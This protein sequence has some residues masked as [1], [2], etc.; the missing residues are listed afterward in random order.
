ME[1]ILGAPHVRKDG[2]SGR[3]DAERTPERDAERV[4]R[5]PAEGRRRE[6]QQRCDAEMKFTEF[7]E[8]FGLKRLL[9][10]L[11]TFEHTSSKSFLSS[12]SI[13]SSLLSSVSTA[14]DRAIRLS[15]RLMTSSA[16]KIEA[17]RMPMASMAIQPTAF[18]PIMRAT[19]CLKEV[20]Q[21]ATL[22]THL[23]YII[24]SVALFTASSRMFSVTKQAE[25]PTT[26]SKSATQAKLNH[27]VRPANAY[28]QLTGSTELRFV[29]P[30]PHAQPNYTVECDSH[31]TQKK[32]LWNGE[33]SGCLPCHFPLRRH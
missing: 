20:F 9:A 1:R 22:S 8:G 13:L 33:K 2:L 5:I 15:A 23:T 6:L 3:D 21:A 32:R 26:I 10:G 30:P 19:G 7:A 14:F 17:S 12:S 24:G 31:S 27:A 11:P 25:L 16:E 4:L 29:P 18:A 28:N